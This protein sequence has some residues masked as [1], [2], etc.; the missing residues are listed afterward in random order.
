MDLSIIIVNWNSKDY[1]FDCIASIKVGTDEIKSE[2][3][4]I[5][6]GSFDGCEEML[7][8]SYSQVRFIQSDKNVG[9][10]KAN[11]IAFEISRG[12]NL[13]FL[14]PDTIILPSAIKILDQ[15][16]R[17]LPFAGAV[18]ARL[19]NRDGSIQMSCVRCFPTILNQFVESDVLRRWFPQSHL[20]GMAPI[21]EYTQSPC[22]VDAVSGAC[23]MIK[24]SAFEEIGMF[25]TDYF[26]YSEDIDICYR[27]RKAG[28][29]TFYVPTAVVVHYGGESSSKSAV[30]VFSSVMMLESRWRYF[31]KTH[32]HLYCWF[33]RLS[34]F[35]ASLGRIGGVTFLW[36]FGVLCG[37]TAKL[38]AI[39]KK[40]LAKLYWSLGGEKWVKTYPASD[41]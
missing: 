11:N 4:V 16:L 37:H 15:Y 39:R 38:A 20:W 14:N 36:P 17:S 18:G 2:V 27:L 9:F 41:E 35:I 19:L 34:I 25:C 7:H 6:S 30:N 12:E 10:A 33:Y 3:V 26:M 28:W 23:L 31:M 24:R 21:F 1:L 29:K 32:S 13:L 22:E 40:W 8:E 5:D